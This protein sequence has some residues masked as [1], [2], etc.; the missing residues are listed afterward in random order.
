MNGTREDRVDLVAIHEPHP[1]ML[2][3]DHKSVEEILCGNLE[4]V[5]HDP[6]LDSRGAEDGGAWLKSHI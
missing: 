5:F 2:G 4:N 1:M 3:L 6:E